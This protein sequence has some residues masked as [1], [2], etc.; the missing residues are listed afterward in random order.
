[1]ASNVAT[2]FNTETTSTISAITTSKSNNEESIHSNL[3]PF[4]AGTKNLSCVRTTST[5][6][7]SSDVNPDQRDDAKKNM[8]KAM[9]PLPIQH[10]WIVYFQRCVNQNFS[11]SL[12]L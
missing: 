5:S 11:S 1:M 3:P 7:S 4:D 8:F 10:Y 2:T 9:R 12:I 6:T